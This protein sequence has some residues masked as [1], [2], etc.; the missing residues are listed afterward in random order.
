MVI[1]SL[2]FSIHFAKVFDTYKSS[3]KLE[4][5]IDNIHLNIPNG[6]I[7]LA[8]CKDDCVTNLSQKCKD[9]FISLGS[10]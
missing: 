5:F 4:A 7:I 8:A 3:K 2:N 9:F 10:E 6:F 1:N